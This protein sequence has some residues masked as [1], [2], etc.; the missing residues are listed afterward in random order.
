MCH[1]LISNTNKSFIQSQG[2]KMQTLPRELQFKIITYLPL[3]ALMQL[4][5]TNKGYH[6]CLHLLL[7]EWLKSNQMKLKTTVHPSCLVRI[8]PV[9]Q[10]FRVSLLAELNSTN[11]RDILIGIGQI[12]LP[13]VNLGFR[14]SKRITRRRRKVHITA[15]LPIRIL[16]SMA[17]VSLQ[18]GNLQMYK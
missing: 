9:P 18:L 10:F 12:R 4:A 15:N 8:Q 13:L 17:S 11:V 2:A 6:E 3:S 7:F 5:Y 1:H 16:V 14:C